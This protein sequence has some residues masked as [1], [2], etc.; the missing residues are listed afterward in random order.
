MNMSTDFN[1]RCVSVAPKFNIFT[2]VIRY[3]KEMI[4]LVAES[5][6]AVSLKG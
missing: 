3:R 5:C 2:S 1:M 4:S 6:L